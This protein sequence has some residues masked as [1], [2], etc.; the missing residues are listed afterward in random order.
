MTS[1][2]LP[3]GGGGWRLLPLLTALL[4]AVLPASLARAA[5][6]GLWTVNIIG[7]SDSHAELRPCT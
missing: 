2:I 3:R 7:Q 1:A 6:D 5:D 4:A